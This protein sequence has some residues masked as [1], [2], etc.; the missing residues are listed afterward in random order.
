MWTSVILVYRCWLIDC[1]KDTVDVGKGVLGVG[2]WGLWAV[3]TALQGP[4]REGGR[5]VRLHCLFLVILGWQRA[6]DTLLPRATAPVHV[7][8]PICCSSGAQS[9]FLPST[10]ISSEHNLHSALWH[11]ALAAAPVPGCQVD[12]WLPHWGPQDVLVNKSPSVKVTRGSCAKPVRAGHKS[13]PLHLPG[14]W[15]GAGW[16]RSLSFNP[17]SVKWR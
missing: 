3:S 9:S 12:T 6:G 13:W 16:L 7:A 2:A 10:L 1:D 5:T 11:R 8:F 14:A 4:R 17:L 15:S